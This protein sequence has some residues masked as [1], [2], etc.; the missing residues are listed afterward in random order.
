MPSHCANKIESHQ[1]ITTLRRWDFVL[2]IASHHMRIMIANINNQFFV[3]TLGWKSHEFRKKSVQCW[4]I[5]FY[6]T[7]IA[8]IPIYWLGLSNSLNSISYFSLLK[9][10]T[11]KLKQEMFENEMQWRET[12]E[13]RN[14]AKQKEW[15]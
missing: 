10:R 13:S 9:R 3:Q 8:C 4:W 2:G 14:E 11:N 5:S 12:K 15:Q 7:M 1:S 6:S